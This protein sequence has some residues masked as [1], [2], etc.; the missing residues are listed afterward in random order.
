M[1]YELDDTSKVEKLFECEVDSLV[2]SCLQGM[3]DSKIYVTDPEHPKSA[4]AHLADF[5]FLAG[6][7]DR[8]LLAACDA[9][10]LEHTAVKCVK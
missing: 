10:D 8:E 1:L 5:A 4:M 3:M 6:E 9:L 2:T 7:P